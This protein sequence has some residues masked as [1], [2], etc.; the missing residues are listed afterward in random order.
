M[1][2]RAGL[3]DKLVALSISTNSGVRRGLIGLAFVLVGILMMLG[4]LKILPEMDPWRYFGPA[5]LIVMGL[6]RVWRPNHET[7]RGG[8]GLW[9]VIIG[10]WLLLVNL[11]VWPIRQ[12]WPFLLVALGLSIVWKAVR[13]GRE[14]GARR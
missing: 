7:G 13:E 3:G 6:G 14:E 12:S 9:L 10:G 2:L 4:Q 1:D 8:G 5:I 11:H